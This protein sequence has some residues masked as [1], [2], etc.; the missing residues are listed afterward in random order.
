VC[1]WRG[2][3]LKRLLV[4]SYFC[5]DSQHRPGG[6]Q[7][8]VG[9]L[10]DVLT[11]SYN[12]TLTV[13]H[14]AACQRPT[15]HI[16]LPSWTSGNEP[17]SV[18]PHV[19]AGASQFLQTLARGHH[20]ALSVDRMLPASLGVPCVLMSNTM[21]YETEATAARANQ[22]R[23]IIAPTERHAA[24]VRM[25][26]PLAHVRAVPYGLPGKL[27]EAAA[28]NSF[29][30]VTGQSQV[31]KL[32]HRPDRRKGHPEAIK[33][34]A[35]ALPAS[36]NVKLQIAWLNE[37]R[38]AAYKDELHRLAQQL[39]VESQ[40][41]F[42][43]WV[44]GIERWKSSADWTATLQLGSFEESFGLSIVESI[45]F[46]RPVVTLRQPAVR[47][48]LGDT[49]LLLEIDDPHNWYAALCEY[50]RAGVGRPQFSNGLLDLLSLD[51][52][53]A[54]YDKILIEANSADLFVHD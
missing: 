41:E 51:R 25:V 4:Y 47:E 26:R 45:L 10:L 8:I 50:W 20:A 38:Y 18:D 13:V 15:K 11:R 35:M 31:I 39:G 30:L 17:D 7:Q 12:W 24:L 40:V 21:A 27:L 46:G 3:N 43:P 34:L 23:T 54:C 37:K 5:P 53:A 22:W 1:C 14:G 16:C 48:I 9:P 19:L 32:P 49:S 2:F 36:K 6:V 52:M 44:D 42:C 33:G 28:S 29:P